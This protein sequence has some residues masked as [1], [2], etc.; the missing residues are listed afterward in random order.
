MKTTIIG[1]LAIL[2]MLAAIVPSAFALTDTEK[3]AGIASDAQGRACTFGLYHDQ[4]LKQFIQ[5]I[6]KPTD[7]WMAAIPRD[8]N[9]FNNTPGDGNRTFPTGDA[10]YDAGLDDG[11]HGAFE[12]YTYGDYCG[13]TSDAH[14]TENRYYRGFIDGL[15]H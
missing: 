3:E 5:E 11:K 1:G 2:V 4:C 7:D 9:T 13:P 12:S 10:C 6:N 14:H 15:G 8:N